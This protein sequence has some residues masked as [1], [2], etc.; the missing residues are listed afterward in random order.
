LLAVGMFARLEAELGIDLPLATLFEAPSIEGL[1]AFIRDIARPTVGRAMVAIQPAG[2][3]PPIFGI[4]GVG[5]GILGY[6]ALARLLGPDQ[7]FYGLQ[8]RGLDGLDRPLTR[9]E[10]I[11]AACVQEIRVVQRQGPYH[12]VG[13][14]LGGVV[15]WEIA[16]QLRA[17]GQ[18]VGLLALLE[19][20]PPETV[21]THR[22]P[23]ASRPAA[24]AAFVT[25]R[26]RL[27]RDALAPLRGRDRLRYLL[28]RLKPLSDLVRHGDPFRGV[29]AE[30]HR[31]AVARA[32]LLAF[33]RYEP[34][35]YPGPAVLIYAEGRRFT[36]PVDG[37]L[38]WRQLTGD[39]QVYGVPG[40]DSGELLREPHVRVVA[41]QLTKCLQPAQPAAPVPRRA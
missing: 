13:M 20:W 10:D 38:R 8:S 7:P 36:G 15:A 27:Y 23:R 31:H 3:R 32:N 11:A 22:H 1:A 41:A 40:D 34:R 37:R 9:I 35:P 24:V 2:S 6:H 17:A 33:Q 28:G 26:L 25:D 14:C 30:F 16:Q 29:L 4:P 19:T 5:G 12:L 39:L 21:S 18:E